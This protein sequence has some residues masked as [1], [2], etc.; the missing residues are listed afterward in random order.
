VGV[1]FDAELMVGGQYYDGDFD[2]IGCGSLQIGIYY[3]VCELIADCFMDSLRL[4]IKWGTST[5]GELDLEA[6]LGGGSCSGN[7]GFNNDHTPCDN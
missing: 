5:G 7:Q 6:S 3:D 1:F 4:D 2:L